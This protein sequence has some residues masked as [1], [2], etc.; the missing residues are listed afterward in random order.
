MTSVEKKVVFKT[1]LKMRE[2]KKKSYYKHR[3]KILAFHRRKITCK[4]CLAI[5]AY[6]TMRKHV[7]SKRC[8]RL[9]L[10]REE[11]DKISD[12]AKNC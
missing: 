9:S 4:H 1:S 2:K 6:S 3:E 12:D 10:L 8:K 5:V 7:K 11:A